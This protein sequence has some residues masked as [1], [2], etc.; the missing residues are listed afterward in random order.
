[1][2]SI[3]LEQSFG[4]SY[5][6][7]PPPSLPS[8]PFFSSLVQGPDPG[9]RPQALDHAINKNSN[10]TLSFLTAHHILASHPTAPQP[11]DSTQPHSPSLWHNLR[12]RA[13]D[14]FLPRSKSFCGSLMPLEKAS[15]SLWAPDPCPVVLLVRLHR[16]CW[17]PNM[18]HPLLPQGL[19]GP[20]DPCLAGLM[21]SGGQ[22][23]ADMP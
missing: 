2:A 22:K 12:E 16:P 11:S 3:F 23:E 13:P 21:F 5:R 17:A 20:L 10:C 18:P 15:S 6:F 14:P 4:I 7:V 9:S 19:T 8:S 1:M